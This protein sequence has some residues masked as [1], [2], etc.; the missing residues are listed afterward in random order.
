MTTRDE[1][2]AIVATLPEDQL[3]AARQALLD[4]AIPEDDEP[5]T[6]DE[7]AA[8]ERMDR[9]RDS[10]SLIPHDEVRRRRGTRL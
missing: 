5:L 4:L 9:A 2:Y 3:D 10:G 1:I 8:I 7:I 6:P